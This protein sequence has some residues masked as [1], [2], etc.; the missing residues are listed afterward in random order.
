M[1]LVQ[2]QILQQDFGGD[3]DKLWTKYHNVINKIKDE[4]NS[5]DPNA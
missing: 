2:K 4:Q 5:A 3:W 1:F